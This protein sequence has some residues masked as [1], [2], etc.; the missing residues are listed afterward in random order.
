MPELLNTLDVA[1]N[2]DMAF[3]EAERLW[4][5]GLPHIG[6]RPKQIL[7]LEGWLNCL[8][9]AGRGW[10]KTQTGA[11]WVRRQAGLYPGVIIHVVAPT[12]SDLRGTV[13]EGPA[14]LRALIP[15]DCVKTLT[16]SPYPEMTLW[17]GS[18]IRG[19]SSETPDRLRGPQCTFVWGDELAAWYKAEEALYNINFSTRIA[20]RLPDGTLVQPQKF[21]TTTPKPL[22]FLADMI[23]KKK[24][25]GTPET[26]LIRGST[27]E[28]RANLAE[29]FFEDLRQY[30]GTNIGRQELHGELLDISESAIIKRSWLKLWPKDEPLP[31]LEFVMVSMDTAF[32]EKT[33]DRKTFSSDPTACTVWGAFQHK[34]QWHLYLLECWEEWLGFPDLIEK[35]KAEMKVIYGRRQE[36]LQETLVGQKYYQEQTK[37][38]DLLIIEDK[39]SGISLRQ[40]LSQ[41]GI[42][43][44]PYNPGRADKLSRL[45]AVSHIARHGRIWLPESDKRPGKPKDWVEPVLKQL[46]VYSG[47]G[48]TPHDDWVDSC[49]QAWRVFSD[50]FVADGVFHKLGK[51]NDDGTIIPSPVP[52]S[53]PEFEYQYDIESGR[54]Q[55]K[56]VRAPYD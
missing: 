14:G 47:P 9:M 24:K 37:H 17:N 21:Y 8:A 40:V 1:S 50:R 35:A 19:F 23:D 28:N 22:Q 41:H 44:F 15:A 48:T 51:A 30:E 27:Y 25:D 42:D 10:G 6:G 32:T 43:S 4:H 11:S 46:C 31:W 34:R 56:V 26:R 45:H 33:Y 54:E 13:F 20:Y 29:N 55:P 49:S 16:Y 39:G 12:Y 18:V 36:M 3:L 38:P 7:P 5:S 53:S 2:A 52:M